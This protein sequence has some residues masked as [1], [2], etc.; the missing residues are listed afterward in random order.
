MRSASAEYLEA[1]K[2]EE[3]ATELRQQGYRVTTHAS[4]G[5]QQFD[6]LAERDGERLAYEVKARQRL[7]ASTD[8]VLR[9]RA[10]AHAAGLSGFRLVVVTP[11]RPVDVSIENLDDALS[12]YLLLA[13]TP[14][15]LDRLSS[16]TRIIGVT[17]VEID[18]VTI[19]P[20]H[21][22]V[23]GNGTVEV[24][25]NFGGGIGRDG[26]TTTESFPFTFDLELSPELKLVKMH[27]LHV[28]T[29]DGST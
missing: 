14:P 20:S 12:T 18:A 29:G 19:Q 25:L 9:L 7:A 17:D 24:E 11:P 4:L 3:L 28:D 13:E 5:N 8:D 26:V 15:E 27:E 22:R 2:I 23:R 21:I 6:L 10:A 1:A 16:E